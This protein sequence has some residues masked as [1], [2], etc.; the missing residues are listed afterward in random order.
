LV[1]AGKYRTEDQLKMQTIQKLNI[2][3]K[4]QTMQNTA[5]Q[6][7]TGLVTFYDTRPPN[8]VGLFYN[9]PEPMQGSYTQ[10]LETI[11]P[12]QLLSEI[13]L[14]KQKKIRDEPSDVVL[15]VCRS[16]HCKW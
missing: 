2:T 5:K 8:E 3:H 7:Y 15:T 9:A 14:I 12:G 13:I 4:K 1:Y 6:N 10:T 11:V 16:F